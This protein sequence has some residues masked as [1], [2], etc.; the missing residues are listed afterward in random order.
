MKRFLSLIILL[1]ALTMPLHAQNILK[2]GVKGG[3]DIQEMKF[4]E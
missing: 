2:L 4:D 3:F 1:S